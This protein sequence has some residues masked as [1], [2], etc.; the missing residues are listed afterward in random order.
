MLFVVILRDKQKFIS[1]IKFCKLKMEKLPERPDLT[2]KMYELISGYWTACAIQTTAQLGIADILSQGPKTLSELAEATQ[3]HEE[4]LY[5]L[6]RA[7]TSVGIFEEKEDNI[8]VL[9]DLGATLR[10]NVPGSM[11]SMFLT[12]VGEFYPVLGDLSYG[13]QTG[14]VAFEHVNGAPLWKYLKE[15]PIAGVHMM[16][17]MTGVSGAV[18]KEILNAYDFT[19]Y[20]TIVDVGGGNG[21]MLFSLLYSSPLSRGT[22]FDEPYVVDETK[23]HIPEDLK[24]RCSVT[25]GSFFKEIPANADLYILKWVIHDWSNEEAIDI[26]NVCC[27]AM[28]VGSKLLII[29]AVIPDELNKPYIGKLLDLNIMAL[30]T[31]IERTLHE[32]KEL[33]EKVNLSFNRLIPTNGDI[34]GIIECEKKAG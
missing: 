14:K 28:R 13:V 8:F 10:S 16:E 1:T 33:L 34:V 18:L 4:S 15:K 30:A 9:N 27:N 17:A 32:T 24:S 29:D 26:L 22:V 2:F 12:M 11:R 7:V 20:S 5:R 21:S 3:S 31:G 23:K 25:S 6:L 19:P